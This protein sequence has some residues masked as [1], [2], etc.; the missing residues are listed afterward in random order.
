M[1][2]PIRVLVVDDEPDNVASMEALLRGNG[3][4]TKGCCQAN[5][6][7]ARVKDY[8]PDAVILD[9]RMPGKSGWDLAEE[10]R[11]AFPGT[12]P[13]LI[14]LTG[15]HTRSVDKQLSKIKGFD[16]YLIKPADPRVLVA[17]LKTVR[18]PW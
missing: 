1:T 11:R 9:L 14:A 18:S 7:F 16:F 8:D 2:G 5:E 15:E 6:A 13:V 10:I 17:M 3:F 4:E 12:R